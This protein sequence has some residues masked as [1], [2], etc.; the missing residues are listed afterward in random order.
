MLDGIK[1]VLFDL[2]GTVIDSMWV[3]E[4]IDIEYL[5]RY[6]VPYDPKYQQDINGLSFNEV[7]IYF[8]DVLG[9][10][11]TT[12]DMK[13]CWNQMAWYKYCNEIEPKKGVVKFLEIL[14]ENGYKTGMGTSNSIELVEAVLSARGLDR[15]FDVV[16][17]SDEVKVGKPAPDIYLLVAK[18]L[19]VDPSEC[20]VFEDIYNGIMAGKNAGMKTC[21]VYDE[22]T[23]RPWQQLVE[24]ANY[25][26]WSFEDDI[27]VNNWRK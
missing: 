5:A 27:I 3:W 9:I 22:F 21:A 20:I 24:E 1:A 10:P 12:E 4:A 18:S 26:I 16:H 7:A 8:R 17:T 6:D 13:S 19:G 14:K 25:S 23:D 11:E 15:Y 2:D